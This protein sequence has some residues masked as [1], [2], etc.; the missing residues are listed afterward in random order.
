MLIEVTFFSQSGQSACDNVGGNSFV[1][2]G[3]SKSLYNKDI[4]LLSVSTDAILVSV[5]GAKR[6]IEPGY[7]KYVAGLYVTSF[8]T[9]TNDACLIV[10]NYQG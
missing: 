5:D 10:R 8:S 4:R 1:V 3:Q 2:G 6:A 7:Q 9:G